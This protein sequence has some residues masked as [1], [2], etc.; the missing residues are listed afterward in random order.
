M[1]SAFSITLGMMILF[2]SF[3]ICLTAELTPIEDMKVAEILPNFEVIAE[4][5]LPKSHFWVRIIRV[6]DHGECN[7]SPETCPKSTIYIAVSEYGE[8]PEQ[9]VFQLEKMHG[10]EFMGWVSFPESEGPDDYVVFNMKAKRPAEDTKDI[11][12]KEHVFGVK[13]NYHQAQIIQK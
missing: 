1:K 13:V 9:K 8:Y 6:A 7:G 3:S 12:W 10:W 5:G 11:W 2:M 4:A